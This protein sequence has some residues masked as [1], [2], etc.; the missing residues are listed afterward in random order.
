MHA[1][2]TGHPGIR[3]RRPADIVTFQFAGQLASVAA[4]V[5]ATFFPGEAYSASFIFDSNAA[6]T[7]SGPVVSQYPL[8]SAHVTIGSYVATGAASA[9]NGITVENDHAVPPAPTF[10][11]WLATSFFSGPPVGSEVVGFGVG[12]GLV[13]GSLMTL[14]VTSRAVPQ[15]PTFA[16]LAGGGL[17]L[18]SVGWMSH[19]RATGPTP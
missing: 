6:P 18:L 19:R 14:S 16:L 17:A 15:P 10:D 3:R 8:I 2:R 5:S 7:L 4:P 11:Q 1:R 9:F 12:G 13:L